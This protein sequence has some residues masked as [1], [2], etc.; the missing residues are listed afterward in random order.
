VPVTALETGSINPAEME[1]I[2]RVLHDRLTSYAGNWVTT[3][4]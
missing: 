3:T 4:D 1:A 2:G